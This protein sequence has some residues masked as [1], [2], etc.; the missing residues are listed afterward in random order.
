MKNRAYG[1]NYVLGFQLVALGDFGVP[2]FTPP[3][4]PA[5]RQELRARCPMNG[6]VN[7]PASKQRAVGRIDNGIRILLRDISL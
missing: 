1:V 2:G 5:F 7:S 4:S 3:Q 6:S